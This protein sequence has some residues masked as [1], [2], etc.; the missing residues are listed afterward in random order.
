[1]NS[2]SDNYKPGTSPSHVL[3]FVKYDTQKRRVLHFPDS[4]IVHAEKLGRNMEQGYEQGFKGLLSVRKHCCN[5][6][7]A[8]DQTSRSHS[9]LRTPFT[10]QAMNETVQ[11]HGNGST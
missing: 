5:V 10:Q 6:A 9:I 2:S 4:C 11:A 8:D 7:A 3:T 1:M